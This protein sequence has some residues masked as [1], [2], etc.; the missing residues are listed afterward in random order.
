MSS[1]GNLSDPVVREG[2]V[3]EPN[4]RGTFGIIWVCLAVILLNTWTVI[5]PNIQPSTQSERRR[6][7]HKVNLAFIA[8]FA[9]DAVAAAAFS[10]WRA[11]RRGLQTLKEDLPWWSLEHAFYAEMG[12]YKVID[13]ESGQEYAFRTPQLAW[14][15]RRKLIEIPHVDRKSLEE[16]SKAEPIGKFIACCHSA[17]FLISTLARIGQHLPITTLEVELFPYVAVTWLIYFWWWKKPMQLTTATLV[18]TKNL[19]P[20]LL[21]EIAETTCC[22]D[23]APPWFR[24]MP[25]E[26][27]PWGWDYYWMTKRIEIRNRRFERAVHLIPPSAGEKV[28]LT[29][30]EWQVAD[31]YRPSVNEGHPNEWDAWDCFVIYLVGIWLYGFPLVVWNA[32]FPTNI[33]RLL[34]RMTNVGS[35]TLI[36]LWAPLGYLLHRVRGRHPAP[37]RESA[38]Y[39][40][41]S[42]VFFGRLYVVVE[43]FVSFRSSVPGVYQSVNWAAYIPHVGR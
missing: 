12:G 11:A 26:M 20:Q 33:E 43:I 28:R 21:I 16:R 24:P 13:E 15:H 23:K 42:I 41:V 39:C 1:A 10:Q 3:S 36:T 27:H 22:F 25:Q 5:H 34:W 4:G 17:W 8:A 40:I 6:Y 9:P 18:P 19:T 32:V 38:Y 14:L 35:I 2:F 7:L 30:A 37:W 29:M 31:W